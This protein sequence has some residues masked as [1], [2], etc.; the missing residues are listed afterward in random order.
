MSSLTGPCSVGLPPTVGALLS[1]PLVREFERLLP[2]A[3]LI[4]YEV[5]STYILEW[6]AQGRIELA[7][8]YNATVSAAHDMRPIVSEE[9]Y[10][11]GPAADA[12]KS[13]EPIDVRDLASYRFI[14]PSARHV[15]RFVIESTLSKSDIEMKVAWEVGS[16]QAILDLVGGG[17]GHA[18]LP[19]SA[20]HNRRAEFSIRP[21]ENPKIEMT[22]SLLTPTRRPLTRL[23]SSVADLIVDLLPHLMRQAS[24][25]EAAAP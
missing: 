22:L 5:L 9:F 18:I 3:Q 19:L 15:R 20:L 25:P 1:L 16:T 10:L 12:K 23:A 17:F 14:V 7:V 21:I 13:T 4:L 24:K 8:V 2:H 11:V 6:L